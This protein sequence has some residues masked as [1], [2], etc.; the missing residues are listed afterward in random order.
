MVTNS[1]SVL[2]GRL[3]IERARGQYGG[4]HFALLVLIQVLP[5]TTV[6]NNRCLTFITRLLYSYIY[7]IQS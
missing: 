5:T 4:L 6:V 2:G 1:Y 7:L 3:Q